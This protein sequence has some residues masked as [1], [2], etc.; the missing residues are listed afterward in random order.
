M[1][2]LLHSNARLNIARIETNYNCSENYWQLFLNSIWLTD[3]YKRRERKKFLMN[4]IE[5]VFVFCL[6]VYKYIDSEIYNDNLS[7]N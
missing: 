2:L 5:K 3:S 7:D 1:L 4:K 6:R